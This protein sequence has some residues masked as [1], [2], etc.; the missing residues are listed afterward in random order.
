MEFP[1]RQALSP[2]FNNPTLVRPNPPLMT[3][4]KQMPYAHHV[5]NYIVKF[6]CRQYG[7]EKKE[8]KKGAL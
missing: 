2:G 5:E 6:S 8:E 7:E 4:I 1:S 3:Y